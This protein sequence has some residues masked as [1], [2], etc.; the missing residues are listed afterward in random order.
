MNL[1]ILAGFGCGTIALL[2]IAQTLA[3]LAIGKR[4]CLLLPYRHDGESSLVRWSM[5]LALH[6]GLLSMIFLYPW[7]I[8]FDPWQYHLERIVPLE[9]WH[10]LAGVGLTAG[11]LSIPLII[12]LAVGWV[13]FENRYRAS[14]L[15][16]KLVRSFLIPIP[17]TLVE[18]PLFRG[19]VQEQFL[20]VFPSS[21]AGW[22]FAVVLSSLIFASVH[23]VKPQ[24]RSLLPFIGLFGLGVILSLAYIRTGHHYLLPMTIH[25]TGVWFVQMTRS[26]TRYGGPAWLVGHASYPICGAMGLTAMTAMGVIIMS[27]YQP[28]DASAASPST[29]GQGLF[30]HQRSVPERK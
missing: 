2:W 26:T 12:S 18:E 23:F 13:K 9:W 19:V 15:I 10:V 29:A 14:K 25:G 27:G 28:G 4:D 20:A 24:K 7:V 17:L 21:A 30:G 11:L 3:L 1:L 22:T 6:A 16:Y 5:K 8:G